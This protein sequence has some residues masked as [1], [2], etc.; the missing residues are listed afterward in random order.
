MDESSADS[1]LDDAYKA[2]MPALELPDPD[3]RHVLAAA[4]F[5]QASAIVTFNLA[6][7][8]AEVLK[9]FNIE[10][11]HPDDFVFH[12]LGLHDASVLI[13]AQRCRKRLRNPPLSATDY[14]D[15]L[16][17]QA[18]PRTVTELRKYAAIL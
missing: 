4:I 16:E 11:Q 2:L 9:R 12:Q 13:S 1:L 10:A 3:D 14:L 5:S 7:F 6:D 15:V 17:R 18:L 8:P